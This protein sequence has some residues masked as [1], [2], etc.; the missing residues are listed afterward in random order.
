MRHPPQSASLRR[1]MTQRLAVPRPASV[2]PRGFVHL[3]V[4]REPLLAARTVAEPTVAE[5]SHQQ[6]LSRHRIRAGRVESPRRGHFIFQTGFYRRAGAGSAH[7]TRG[8][9]TR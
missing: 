6:L 2:S 4:Y 8:D 1:R 9:G 3:G 5:Q 7:R